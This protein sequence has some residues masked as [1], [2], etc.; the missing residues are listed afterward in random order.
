VVD[1]NAMVV[2]RA[3]TQCV[4]TLENNYGDLK[5]VSGKNFSLNGRIQIWTN[6]IPS[7]EI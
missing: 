5:K 2:Y 6:N 4:K 3:D 7:I 1:V